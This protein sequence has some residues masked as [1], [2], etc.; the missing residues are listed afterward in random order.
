MLEEVYE[1]R[2]GSPRKIVEVITLITFKK[3][4]NE[5][6]VPKLVLFDHIRHACGSGFLEL[7]VKSDAFN[8]DRRKG[9]NLD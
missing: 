4:K 6:K 7:C 5:K 9:E 1:K 2:F 8:N 3:C